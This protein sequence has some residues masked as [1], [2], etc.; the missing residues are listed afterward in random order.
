VKHF[1]KMAIA[2]LVVTSLLLGTLGCATTEQ[3]TPTAAPT[4]AA[5]PTDDA[6][7]KPTGDVIEL[8]YH[9]HNPPTE[10]NSVNGHAVLAKKIEEATNGRVK[11]T[12][13]PAETLGKATSAMDMAITGIADISWG[14]IGNFPGRFPVTDLLSL[15]M[16]GA[17][18]AEH[19]SKVAMEMFNTTPEMQKE[20]SDVK[21]LFLH[22][23]S[24]HYVATTSQKVQSLEDLN[25]L[26]VRAIPGAPLKYLQALGATPVN[27][28]MPETYEALEKGT[29]D[30][31]CADWSGYAGFKLDDLLSYVVEEPLY[32]NTFFLV[33][34]QKKW[35]SLPPDVQ[36][37]IES[38]CG[39]AGSEFISQVWDEGN[40]ISKEK[41]L[42][43]GVEVIKLS[44]EERQRW[45][46]AAPQVWD[47]YIKIVDSKGYDGQALVDKVKGLFEQYKP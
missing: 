8:K 15:P 36:E 42:A 13:F 37:A 2:V 17:V 22:T 47:E 40:E 38:V 6:T 9:Q 30:A 27:I 33:M 25:G 41:T 1:V 46:E 16:M 31:S 26:R 34:N 43:K 20:F 12:V 19:G 11:V 7:A 44:D 5:Q 39:E 18:S 14:Y 35:D 28:S 10:W 29:A 3:P 4:T 32:V 21:V 24:P 23:I 45:T